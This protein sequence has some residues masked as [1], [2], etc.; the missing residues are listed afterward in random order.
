VR[1]LEFLRVVVDDTDVCAY[2]PGQTARMPLCLP[3]GAVTSGQLDEIL[4]AG[5]RRSGRF[6]YRTRCPNCSACEPLRLDVAQFTPSRSQ[7]R[8]KQKGDQNLQVRIGA[9]GIDDHRIR[10]FN[11]HRSDRNLDHGNPPVDHDEYAAFL[12]NA[13]CDV[14]E[15]SFWHQEQLIAIS[16]TDVGAS[17]FSAVYCFFDPAASHFSPG[18][19]AILKQIELA[20]LNQRQWLYLGLYVS[21]NRHLN[22]KAR[23]R[24]HQRRQAGEWV[25]FADGPKLD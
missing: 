3:N 14:I 9:A 11:A 25:D 8:A 4:E 20:Q 21:A 24:P 10:L 7:R 2:L 22:Y 23:F 6:F 13:P 19:Y 12:L 18:T 17:S 15:L 5:Y 16:I 1:E